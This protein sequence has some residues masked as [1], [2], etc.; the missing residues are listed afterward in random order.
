MRHLS[1]Y[2][3]FSLRNLRGLRAELKALCE[4]QGLLGTILISAEGLNGMVTGSPE[5]VGALKHW[6]E[7]FGVQEIKEHEAEHAFHRLLLKIKKEIISVGDPSLKPGESTAPRIS[8]AELKAWLDE[9]RS[10]RLLD[11]RNAYE[12][13]VG[14]FKGAEHWDLD[15]S[16]EFARK[17][18]GRPV[19]REPVVTFC[20]GGIRCEKASALLQ[21]LGWENVYQLDG[22]I[23][24]YFED[25][26]ADHFE[27][28]CF[29]FDWRLAVDGALKPVP[30]SSDSG[31]QF[32]RHKI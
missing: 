21:K 26:G 23:L 16:R 13:E 2:R 29:V 4:A 18:A 24:G 6:L 5:G 28:S 8:P 22:G 3:F 32:G 10:F 20:T 7:A 25:V 27:G 31:K 15:S 30:R 9:G 14:T 11:T 19:E 1:F 12:V 17:A